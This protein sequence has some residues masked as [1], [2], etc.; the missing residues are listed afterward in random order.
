MTGA[1]PIEAQ[2]VGLRLAIVVPM[3]NEIAGAEICVR[4]LIDLLPTL[5]ISAMLIVVDDGSTDG[6]A[7][8]LDELQRDPGGFHV[9]HKPNGGYGSALVSGAKSAIE[10]GCQFVLFMDSD[11]TNP[12]E[13]VERFVQPM[14]DGVDVVKGCRFGASGDMA[15]VPWRRRLFSISGNVVARMCFRMGLADCTNGFRAIRAE[16]FARMPLKERGF[17]V[18][19]EEL[20]WAKVAGLTVASVPT[21]LSSRSGD[22]RQTT[23]SYQP[24]M[25]WQYV[26]FAL[27]AAVVPYRPRAA[28]V[29][30]R[31]DF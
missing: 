30:S 28:L 19:L 6:T 2:G 12:P 17:A 18:I 9:V 13:H 10:R 4:R 7:A 11:L 26:K 3:F 8:K 14:L 25:L 23:F 1:P 24:A 21:S 16:A 22:Q 5:K 15:A 27:R 29:G 31:R 20:Y